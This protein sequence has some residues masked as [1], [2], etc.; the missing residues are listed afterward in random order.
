LDSHSLL[1]QCAGVGVATWKGENGME[2]QIE[3]HSS[4]FLVCNARGKFSLLVKSMD[5]AF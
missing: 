4:S 1:L 3:F 2:K 5:A